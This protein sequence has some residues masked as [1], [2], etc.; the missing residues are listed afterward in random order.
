MQRPR[1]AGSREARAAAGVRGCVDAA[2]T[3]TAGGHR[4]AAIERRTG[5]KPLSLG[6]GHN[7][8]RQPP[9]QALDG[10]SDNDQ[11]GVDALVALV[12]LASITE[13]MSTTVVMR[14][15]ELGRATL[16]E[17]TGATD[18]SMNAVCAGLRGSRQA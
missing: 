4:D 16:G 6:H 1:E 12:A 10:R 8:D 5:G 7:S 18:A 14:H 17:P 9:R 13:P 2:G 15:V 3:G 11:T